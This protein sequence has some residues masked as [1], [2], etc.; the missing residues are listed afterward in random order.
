ME[1]MITG[2][3]I[4]KSEF[5]NQVKFDAERSSHRGQQQVLYC[6]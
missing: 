5:Q 1:W 4:C 6:G 3:V 2:L